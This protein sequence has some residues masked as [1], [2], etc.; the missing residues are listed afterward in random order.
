MS[1]SWC[2]PGCEGSESMM[3]FRLPTP[4]LCLAL[5]LAL[6]GQLGASVSN[7]NL[8]IWHDIKE[9]KTRGA[10]CNDFSP[11]GYFLRTNIV[12]LESEPGS[13][14]GGNPEPDDGG[15]LEPEPGSM[16]PE[17][18]SGRPLEPYDEKLTEG[19]NGSG[20]PDDVTTSPN[21][22]AIN[23]EDN[24]DTTNFP[25]GGNKWVI[26]LEGG[27]GCTTPRLCNERFIDQTIRDQFT[28]IVDGVPSVDVLG[29]WD[30]YQDSPLAV[31]SKLMTS[32]SRFRREEGYVGIHTEGNGTTSV[33]GVEGRTILSTSPDEN[34]DFYQHNHV[35]IPYCSSDLWLERT[36]YHKALFSNFT[37]Q[38]DPRYEDDHQFTFR[39]AAIF[40][41]VVSDLFQLYG[42][43]G[44]DEVVLVGSSAGGVGVM[45]HAEWLREELRGMAPRGGTEGKVYVVLDSAWFIDF[46]GEITQQVCMC[47]SS[48]VSLYVPSSS[49][50]SSPFLLP[51]P[52]SSLPPPPPPPP[53]PPS[54]LLPP[55][56][57]LSWPHGLRNPRSFKN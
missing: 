9:A 5:C 28:S 22:P 14:A 3:G 37:F 13:Y 57:S 29:A 56:H 8:L 50:S 12:I 30:A 39:G 53:P 24:D 47:V 55:L 21:D 2:R 42:L 10:L 33:W 18:D 36:N 51:L 34:P 11:A 43:S 7:S 38:F 20:S 1:P 40:R 31:T 54:F 35:L 23:R 19:S 44:A 26:Y 16:E 49:S 46:R 25:R 27:G 52:S 32:L 41:S 15:I 4:L 17:S 6:A 48:V 45:N